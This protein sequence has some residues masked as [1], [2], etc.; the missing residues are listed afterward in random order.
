MSWASEPCASTSLALGYTCVRCH[1]WPF[2]FLYVDSED[3]SSGPHTCQARTFTTERCLSLR[4]CLASYRLR[5]Q[6]KAT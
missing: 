6:P 2:P 4:S 3:S 5:G 1:K